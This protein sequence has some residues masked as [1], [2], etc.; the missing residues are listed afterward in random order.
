MVS[1]Q[2]ELGSAPAAFVWQA[3]EWESSRSGKTWRKTKRVWKGGNGDDYEDNDD[4]FVDNDDINADF[5][6]QQVWENM[7]ENKEGLKM[8]L[9]MMMRNVMMLTRT[10]NEANN[11][12]LHIN[13]SDHSQIFFK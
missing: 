11:G 10:M 7:K 13:Y 5:G 9:F 3:A 8:D 6:K 2:L 1:T 12:Q 4:D